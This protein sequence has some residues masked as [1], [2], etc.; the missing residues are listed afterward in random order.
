MA[1]SSNIG[2]DAFAHVRRVGRSCERIHRRG[3]V[4]TG[5]NTGDAGDAAIVS[6]A[7]AA[8]CAV[9]PTPGKAA[10]NSAASALVVAPTGTHLIRQVHRLGGTGKLGS[11]FHADLP[12]GVLA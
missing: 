10:I 2:F 8:A 11:F 5:A 3:C 1:R 4:V 7:S 9:G 12:I 6:T